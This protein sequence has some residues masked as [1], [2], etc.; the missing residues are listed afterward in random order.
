MT[1][2]FHY[3]ALQSK[4][5]QF[6]LSSVS[7]WMC[8]CVCKCMCVYILRNVYRSLSVVWRPICLVKKKKKSMFMYV[9]RTPLYMHSYWVWLIFPWTTTVQK[10]KT[11]SWKR[12]T[13]TF[14]R[15][16]RKTKEKTNKQKSL[17]NI[18]WF[19]SLVI[20]Y[21]WRLFSLVKLVWEKYR[22]KMVFDSWQCDA[23]ALHQ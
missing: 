1:R 18:L 23:G 7:E 13:E 3:T 15:L 6:L 5:W 17:R 10:H 22:F 2:T 16:K 14:P 8:E 21:T 4:Q 9:L 20:W 11:L 19:P 12:E